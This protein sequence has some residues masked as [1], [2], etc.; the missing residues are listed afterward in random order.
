MV[1]I[2]NPE[3]ILLGPMKARLLDARKAIPVRPLMK[4]D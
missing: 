4:A 3:M 2:A 1:P